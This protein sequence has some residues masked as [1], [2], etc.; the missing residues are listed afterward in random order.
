MRGFLGKQ[1]LTISVGQGENVKFS[2]SFIENVSRWDSYMPQ[3]CTILEQLQIIC[4]EN[5]EI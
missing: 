1:S 4:G 3:N 2:D 5:S